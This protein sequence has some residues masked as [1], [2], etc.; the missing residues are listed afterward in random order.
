MKKILFIV[1]L[2]LVVFL[3]ASNLVNGTEESISIT[4]VAD[5]NIAINESF[6][7]L[8]G[9][10]VVDGNGKEVDYQIN[11]VIVDL[12]NDV[13]SQS[14]DTSYDNKY[15]I[16]YEALYHDYVVKES[17]VLTVGNGIALKMEKPTFS[18]LTTYK[19]DSKKGI[20]NPLLNVYAYDY[21]G[22][23]IT[24]SITY[25]IYSYVYQEEVEEI[26]MKNAD[27]YRIIYSVTDSSNQSTTSTRYIYVGNLSSSI[28]SYENIKGTGY[29]YDENIS[30]YELVYSDEF[31][32]LD[33]SKYIF[34]TGNGIQGFGNWELEY[35]TSRTENIKAEN[36]NLVITALKESY[37][38]FNYTSAKITSNYSFKYGVIEVK[39]KLPEGIGTWP[40]IWMLPKEYTWGSWPYCGEIDIM[41]HVG[42][43]QGNVLGTI[44][45]GAFNGSNGL[46]KSGHLVFDDVST[47][48][49]IYKLEW[50]PDKL[51]FYIDDYLYFEYVP[52]D[53]SSE[54]DNDY[55]PF[56]KD[57]RFILNVA[58]GGLFGG[59]KGV[60]DSKLPQ[61]MYVD[62]VHIYQSD[63]I[64]S[65]IQL[66]VGK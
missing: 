4:G 5:K 41:E 21:L 27:M 22:H 66:G 19:T 11:T 37:S 10:G 17:M 61:S 65:L 47:N 16:E 49:H 58:I 6:N 55:W 13:I 3:Q 51:K 18:G 2:P 33:K 57:Y 26:N 46:Q 40:A 53:Y 52:G 23:D 1:L 29:I 59:K 9:I 7:P 44:H 36:G 60:D 15:R 50:L 56:D 54:P 39:A 42:Y 45:T 62:Y 30:D 32:T 48:Y 25:K 24:S 12:S 34:E 14:L 38:G 43:D 28:T 64:N 8:S 31:D 35:Y 20:Y 63:Y